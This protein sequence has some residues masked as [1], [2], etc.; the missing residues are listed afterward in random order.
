MNRNF[1]R[2]LSAGGLFLFGCS[3]DAP[4]NVDATSLEPRAQSGSSSEATP[5]SF[6]IIPNE[7]V[8]G[9]PGTPQ[10]KVTVT[11]AASF[12]R[13]MQVRSNNSTVLPFL[14]S[15]VTVSAGT[16]AT[17][18]QIVPSSVS[19]PTVVTIFITG[20][21]VTVSADLLVDPEGTPP[22]PPTL[23][24]VAVSPSTVSAGTTAMGTVTLPNPAGTD[25]VVVSL[26]S[27][28]PASAS[29]PESFTV[30][31]GATSASFPVSTFPGFP[32][33]TTTVLLTASNVNTTVS[34]SITVVTGGGTSSPLSA[35]AL[36]TPSSDARLS[37][38]SIVAFDWTD[39]AGAVSYTIQIGSKD[40]FPSPLITSQTVT[41]S[42]TS[43]PGLPTQT[44]W[45]RVRANAS[46]GTNSA[47]STVRRFELK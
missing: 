25:G 27:R 8:G 31:A 36:L 21:G 39:V 43:I 33:S 44:M 47:W 45:W 9:G 6:S 22:P 17:A 4:T 12:D 24:S 20:N 38:G 42:Q 46:D 30:P 16:T 18:V 3:P 26:S 11:F 7:V 1:L 32:N 41:S 15:A 29:M 34:T 40:N 35:P 23:S 28:V 13:I 14:P 37:R 10:G 2:T 19:T 5:V